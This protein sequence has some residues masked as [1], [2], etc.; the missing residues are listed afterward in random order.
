MNS[1]NI[2]LNSGIKSIP[3]G[4]PKNMTTPTKIHPS[5]LLSTLMSPIFNNSKTGLLNLTKR[6]SATP[7]TPFKTPLIKRITVT[8][9]KK[10]KEHRSLSPIMKYR[11]EEMDCEK[12]VFE[13]YRALRTVGQDREIK[14][15]KLVNILKQP[16]NTDIKVKIGY[17][18]EIIEL[19]LS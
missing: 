18:M 19:A 2:V 15:Q 5:K 10:F 3:K 14:V 9:T 8:S 13:K 17:M 6:D 1:S 7:I 4:S 16:E 11:V 12:K